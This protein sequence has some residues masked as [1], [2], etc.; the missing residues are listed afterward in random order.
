MLA[1]RPEDTNRI[2]AIWESLY[3][4][5]TLSCSAADDIEKIEKNVTSCKQ[6][7]D[8]PSGS[9]NWKEKDKNK[10]ILH[11]VLD[12]IK[13]LQTSKVS[14]NPGLDFAIMTVSD[15]SGAINNLFC[16]PEQ[17]DGI[18]DSIAIGQVIC[19]YCQKKSW[20]GKESVVVDDLQII[21]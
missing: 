15:N 1:E 5:I 17:Y 3:L 18:K 21:G 14:K 13:I 2:K 6:A 12:D 7:H 8:M 19:V 11:V 20:K 10:L 4:G 16:W 9:G